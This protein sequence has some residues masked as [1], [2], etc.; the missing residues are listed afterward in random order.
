M[1]IL[2]SLEGTLLTFE[3]NSF[4]AMVTYWREFQPAIF[5]TVLLVVWFALN[6]WI[7]LNH[8]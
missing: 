3:T 5:I 2:C 6:I 7:S 8:L 4:N 1:T